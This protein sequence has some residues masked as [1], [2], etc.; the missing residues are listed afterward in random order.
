MTPERTESIRP[1]AAVP[2]ILGTWLAVFRPC[3]TA[4]VWNHILLLVAGAVLAP[5]KRTVTQALR[6]MGRA[7]QPG[8]G[9]YHEALNRARWD[10]RDVARRLLLHLFLPYYGPA[11]R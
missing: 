11:A 8:F 3:F 1:A 9:R 10:S 5:G 4:P 2:P 6:V 7:D